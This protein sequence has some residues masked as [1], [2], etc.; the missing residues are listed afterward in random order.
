VIDGSGR[1]ETFGLAE[2]GVWRPAPNKAWRRPLSVLELPGSDWRVRPLGDLRSGGGWGLETRAQKGREGGDPS[3]AR[4]LAPNR[5]EI[6]SRSE[7]RLWVGVGNP[8]P[9]RVM[10]SSSLAGVL[11]ESCGRT[12][13]G[14][15]SRGPSAPSPDLPAS[16]KL[17]LIGPA[18]SA[19]WES[20]RLRLPIV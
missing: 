16:T 7:A 8:R 11:R 13:S 5:G 10:H 1:L 3:G 15:Q 20:R 14:R 9:T 18:R 2:G 6:P 17:L 19:L 4:R 12:R